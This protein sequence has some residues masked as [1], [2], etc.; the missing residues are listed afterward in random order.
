MPGRRSDSAKGLA[1]Y[2]MQIECP[3]CSQKM[4]IHVGLVG[5]SNNKSIECVGCHNSLVPL[6][7]GPIV[8][9][10]FVD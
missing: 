2:S 7:P 4:I 9:G 5:T 10:P 8:D 3:Q 1:Q 6:C